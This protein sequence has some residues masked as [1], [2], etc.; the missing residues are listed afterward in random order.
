[1]EWKETGAFQAWVERWRIGPGMNDPPDG[2]LYSG[3]DGTVGEGWIPILDQL[4]D[5]LVRMGWDRQLDQV[6]E[7]YGKLRFYLRTGTAEREDRI[8]RAISESGRTCEN[9]S[10]AGRRA[11]RG[12]I[13]TLC[14]PCRT[15]LGVDDEG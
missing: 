3:F 6:K 9:C 2:G 15:G 1:M 4:A 8:D 13:R 12:W 11:G 5:D 10:A 14:D 7:K